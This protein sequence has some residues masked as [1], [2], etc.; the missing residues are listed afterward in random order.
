MT[1][2]V[3]ETLSALAEQWRKEAATY[4]RQAGLAD[5]SRP[6]EASPEA[7]GMV[8]TASTLRNCAKQLDDLVK[9][10]TKAG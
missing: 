1:L 6:S 3:L 2:S 9:K 8:C 7:V 10:E 4:S 5:T